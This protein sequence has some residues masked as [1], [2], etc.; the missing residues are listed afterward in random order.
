MTKLNNSMK[1]WIKQAIVDVPEPFTAKEIHQRILDSRRNTNFV[2][3]AWSVAQYL[4]QIC[5]KERIGKNNKYWRKE[6]EN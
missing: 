3:N 5:Y 1:K 2:S 6:N 4:N